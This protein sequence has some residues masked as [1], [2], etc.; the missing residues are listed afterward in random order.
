MPTVLP[1]T[2]LY[3]IKLLFRLQH[4][5]KD[6][7]L[8]TQKTKQLNISFLSIQLVIYFLIAGANSTP[9]KNLLQAR[10][11]P[12]RKFSEIPDSIRRK[13]KM[14]MISY[15]VSHFSKQLFCNSSLSFSLVTQVTRACMNSIHRSLGITSKS[16][17]L[18][19]GWVA[20]IKRAEAEF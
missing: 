2:D 4:T 8:L 1:I 15:G 3:C 20:S 7:S 10:V 16:F 6:E 12:F 11:L 14:L 13:Y 19:L 5:H 17:T 18:L 9:H